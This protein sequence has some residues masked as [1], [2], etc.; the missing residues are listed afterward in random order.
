MNMNMGLGLGFA[1]RRLSDVSKIGEM[2]E[3]NW[4]AGAL[5]KRKGKTDEEISEI[6]RAMRLHD[7]G[8]GFTCATISFGERKDKVP[9]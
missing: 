1:P 2:H 4:L 9:R 7:D 3:H 5:A 8:C 6:I